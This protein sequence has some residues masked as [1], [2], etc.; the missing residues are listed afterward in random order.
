MFEVLLLLIENGKIVLWKERDDRGK[1]TITSYIA[2]GRRRLHYSYAN[3]SDMVES[4]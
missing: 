1:P 4:G 2:A 3:G